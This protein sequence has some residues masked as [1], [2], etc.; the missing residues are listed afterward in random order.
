MN[1]RSLF[2]TIG[3]L[4]LC[5][6]IF[7]IGTFIGGMVVVMLGLQQPPVP[8]GMDAQSAMFLLLLESPLFALVLALLARH[9]AGGF[10][11]RAPMLFFLAWISN[12][13]NNQIEAAAFAG[14]TEGFLFTVLTFLV[15]ALFIGMA[16]AWLFPPATKNTFVDVARSFFSRYPPSGWIWRLL[17]AAV[18]FMPIYYAFG[19]IVIP[20]TR[21][22]Y[23][24]NMY[25]LQIPSLDK[26]LVVLFIR[27][28][29]F[30]LAS[31]PV[32]IAWQSSKRSLV[33]RLGLALFYLVGFQSLL[34]ANWMPW[35]LRLPHML[36][37]LAGEFV[38]AG[39]LVILLGIGKRSEYMSLT[40]SAAISS[41]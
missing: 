21:S 28:V 1:V 6:V 27:S 13:V 39:V 35:A 33:W 9:L 5:G 32:L 3:K 19:L 8:E 17:L 20:F 34:A 36:E 22:Y 31:L 4:L 11:V 15:P 10:W 38:Y 24:Q 2:A 23:E 37:I 41:G 12:S 18:V 30:F 26:L 14:M 16:V 7:A 29:L 25:S 40:N